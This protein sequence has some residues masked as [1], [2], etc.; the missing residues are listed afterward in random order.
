LAGA[1]AGL[2]ARADNACS[3]AGVMSMAFALYSTADLAMTMSKFCALANYWTS[4][5]KVPSI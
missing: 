3:T 5:S 1:A 4:P 2:G